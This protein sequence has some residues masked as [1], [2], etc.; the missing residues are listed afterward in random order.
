LSYIESYQ[1]G[2]KWVIFCGN[3]CLLTSSYLTP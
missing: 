1:K 3:I 2:F